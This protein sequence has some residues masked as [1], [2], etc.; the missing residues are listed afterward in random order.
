MN[1]VEE[2]IAFIKDD[3][4]KDIPPEEILQK[5]LI[6]RSSFYFSHVHK[7]PHDE[8]TFRA[9]LAKT[10]NV[11]INDIIIVGS[12]K[13]GFSVKTHNF[14]LFD[15]GTDKFNKSKKSDIDIAVVSRDLFDDLSYQIYNMSRHFEKD[16]KAENWV[17]N[18]YYSEGK[19]LKTPIYNS[20]VEYL[21][22]GWFR[23]DFTPEMFLSSW[24][25]TSVIDNWRKSFGNR[26]IGLGIYSNWVFFKHYHMDHFEY[27]RLK[28][29]KGDFL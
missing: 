1:L 14:V 12:A 23:P 24:N 6:E 13:L 9:D 25:C 7:N 26:K 17:N 20:Y 27:L 29:K 2:N 21:A 15:K 19:T 3:L 22:K 16:W 4:R 10:L 18:R 28:I 5:H 11:N 8:Y